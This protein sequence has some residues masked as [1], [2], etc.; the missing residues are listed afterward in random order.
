MLKRSALLLAYG[1]A[2][3]EVMGRF[4]GRV[5]EARQAYRD[6]VG[7]GVGQGRR[8]DLVGGGLQRSL[9]RI[10]PTRERVDYDQRVLG[11]SDFVTRLREEEALR[12]RLVPALALREVVDRIAAHYS[13]TAEQLLRKTRA[14]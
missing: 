1:Q 3:D 6:F 7:A 13:V 11:S 2:V 8:D 14:P 12:D 5:D 9:R 4:G 10:G